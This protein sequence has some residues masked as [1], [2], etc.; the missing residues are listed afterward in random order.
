[1]NEHLQRQADHGRA[2]WALVVI[3]EWLA[4]LEQSDS[5]LSPLRT[6]LD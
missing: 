4:W 5:K 6:P 2:I 1:M 3:S